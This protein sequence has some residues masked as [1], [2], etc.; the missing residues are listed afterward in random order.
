MLPKRPKLCP[1]AEVGEAF[2]FVRCCFVPRSIAQM[3]CPY[4]PCPCTLA[5]KKY[6][7]DSNFNNRTHSFHRNLRDGGWPGNPV[8]HL[9]SRLSVA[10]SLLPQSRLPPSDRWGRGDG[11][12]LNRPNPEISQLYGV[13]WRGGDGDGGR[14]ADAAGVR[15][16]NLPPLPGIGDSY[17]VG[18]FRLRQFRGGEIRARCGGFGAARYQIFRSGDLSPSHERFFGTHPQFCPLFKRY[19]KKYLDSLCFGSQ[20]NEC[21]GE[22]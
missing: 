8:R 21:N 17:G 18:Y 2:G 10:L 4:R 7:A 16:G 15:P 14:T 12:S 5:R 11:G 9:H 13:F 3:L 22:R 19:R 20:S 6:Y 1:A